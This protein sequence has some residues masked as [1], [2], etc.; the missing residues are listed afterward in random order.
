MHPRQED[1][2]GLICADRCRKRTGA[3]TSSTRWGSEK[4]AQAV[5]SDRKGKRLGPGIWVT[6]DGPGYIAG[7]FDWG[8]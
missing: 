7:A 3:T 1:G 6:K 8:S 5:P 4:E 2:E